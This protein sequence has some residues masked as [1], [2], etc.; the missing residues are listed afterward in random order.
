MYLVFALRC[1]PGQILEILV[2]EVDTADQWV[3]R[4]PRSILWRTKY[5]LLQRRFGQFQ[6]LE[7]LV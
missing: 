3:A 1:G 2:C 5:I 7:N 6:D 4:A